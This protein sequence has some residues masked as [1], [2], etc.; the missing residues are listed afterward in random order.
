VKHRVLF[1]R[2]IVDDKS[3]AQ[4]VRVKTGTR[5]DGRVEI[6]DGLSGGEKIIANPPELTANQAVKVSE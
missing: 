1:A 3:H 2:R 6:L 4:V 5:K